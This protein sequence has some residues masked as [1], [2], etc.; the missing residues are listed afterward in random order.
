VFKKDGTF[1]EEIVFVTNGVPQ[2][3]PWDMGLSTDP[4]QKYMLIADGARMKVFVVQRKPMKVLG[5]FGRPGRMAGELLFINAVAMDS[6]GNVYTGEVT[7]GDRVQKF[8]PIGN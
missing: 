6:K 3:T 2:I 1:V 4:E 5:S 8:V 7:T